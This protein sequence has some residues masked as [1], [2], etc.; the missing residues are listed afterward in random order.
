VALF[1]MRCLFTMFAED[2]GLLTRA[3]F[4]GLLEDYKGQAD[5]VHVPLG[6][7]FAD[8]NKGGYSPELRSDILRFNGG[9]FKDSTA[10]Q[11]DEDDLVL[12]TI[13]AQRDWKDVEPAIFG[14]LLER[15]LDPRDRAKLGAHYTPRA[16][17]ER[18]V[19]ATIIEPLMADWRDVQAAAAQLL[20][21]GEENQARDTVRGFHRELCR[22]RVLDPACGTGNFLYVA[23]ELMKR[24]EGE[25]LETLSDLGETQY[26]LDLDRHTVDPHQF[27]GLE[28][29]NA[30]GGDRRAGALDRLPAVALQDPRAHPAGRAGAQELRQ[31]RRTGRGA[32]LRR[33]GVAARRGRPAD[34]PLG[35]GHIQAAPR[36]RRAS[37]RRGRHG[38]TQEL[39]QP[40]PRHLARGRLHRGESTVH[41]DEANTSGAW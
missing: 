13:A 28:I 33:L 20:E 12:L 23:L 34:H 7:L 3:S 40:A 9:L 6:R 24:L 41:R 32:R 18:L 4:T 26:L 19:V 5:K 16:Y 14:T 2:V 8:M 25:V 17:V 10:L 1:L 11:I 31:H 15:A 29:N 27:L 37:S 22:V 39:P 35:R 36:D 30:R 21:A 38:R